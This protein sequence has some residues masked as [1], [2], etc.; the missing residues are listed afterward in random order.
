[1]KKYPCVEIKPSKMLLVPFPPSVRYY[2][3]G[4]CIV[5]VDSAE[6]GTGWHLSI[7]HPHR[8]PTWDELKAARYAF[9]PKELTFAMLL[10]PEEEYVNFH[11]FCF[12]LY[13]FKDS[14]PDVA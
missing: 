3:F 14:R 4:A 10:P 13:E 12:H 6:P 2:K 5:F 1:M 8:L 9:L 7:S 11:E